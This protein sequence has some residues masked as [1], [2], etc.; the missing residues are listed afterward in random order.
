MSQCL[1]TNHITNKTKTDISN[2]F[3]QSLYYYNTNVIAIG[4]LLFKTILKLHKC[5]LYSIFT[6]DC[7][8][9]T[10]NTIIIRKQNK[11]QLQRYLRSVKQKKILKMIP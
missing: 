6:I 4:D 3:E 8:R 10:V 9:A 11:L 2:K 1:K 5:F 7:K